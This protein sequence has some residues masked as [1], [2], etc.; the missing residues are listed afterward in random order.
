MMDSYSNRTSSIFTTF[1]TV[2]FTFA[3]LNHFTHYFHPTS[4]TASVHL[5]K[6]PN[7]A[8]SEFKNYKADQVKF[9]IDLSVDVRSE[10]SWN[11]N[12][13]YLFVTATYETSKNSRNEIVVFDKIIRDK[14][15]YKFD[16]KQQ[17]IKYFLRDEYKNTLGGK[18]IK[19][20]VKYQVMPIFGLMWT[21]EIPNSSV[22]MVVPSDYSKK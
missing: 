21:K 16:L 11:V 10:Y 4:P 14:K 12:Q 13:L 6:T 9:D 5:S 19:L 3:A 8:F 17:K 1:T 2:L 15:D 20:S 22:D 7:L 18:K